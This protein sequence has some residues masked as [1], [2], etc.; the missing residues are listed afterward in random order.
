MSIQIE[1]A[2]LREIRIA[3]MPLTMMY[4]VQSGYAEFWSDGPP[5]MDAG[6]H[7]ELAVQR[8]AFLSE[9]EFHFTQGATQ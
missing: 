3:N 8:E 1:Q 9:I 5:R 4:S 2:A 7:R 6:H